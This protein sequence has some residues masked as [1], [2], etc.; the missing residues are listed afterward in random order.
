MTAISQSQTPECHTGLKSL[1]AIAGVHQVSTSVD[2]L[3]HEYVLGN[4]ELSDNQLVE[5]A[6]KLGLNAKVVSPHKAG[7]ILAGAREEGKYRASGLL[8]KFTPQ[9]FLSSVT[10]ILSRRAT[11]RPPEKLDL[12]AYIAVFPALAR[13]NN[14]S[15]VV[16]AGIQDRGGETLIGV[17]DPQAA[18]Q[19]VIL[20]PR[21]A[22]EEQWAGALILV[23]RR[24]RLDDT[25]QPFS[26]KWF[27]PEVLRQKDLLRDIILGALAIQVVGLASPLFFRV[28]LDRVLVHQ[29]GATLA[30]LTVGVVLALAFE[31]IFTYL[32][33]LLL[34]QA[35]NK[36]D[37]RLA[38]RTF[39]HLMSLPISYFEVVPGGVT[40]RHLQQ[41]EKIRGFLTGRLLTVALEATTLLVYL[42]LL[43]YF[44]VKLTL[45]V[46]GFGALVAGVILMLV[47]PFRGRLRALY[48]AEAERQA[49]LVETV[50][51]MR[52]VKSLALEPAQ[53][54]NWEE[55]S[56]KAVDLH[57]R[58][59]VIGA[60]G[61]AVTGFL[62]KVMSVAVIS[63]GAIDVFSGELSV[64]A[65]IAF[66][67]LS[68]RVI[69]P[70][71]QGASLIQDYQDTALSVRMLGEVM[72]RQSEPRSTEGGLQ[73]KVAGQIELERVT[74]RYTPG[75]A[76]ALDQIGLRIGAGKLVGVVGRS[77][78]GK[79]TVA[80]LLQGLYPLQ[81]GLIRIDGVD[82]REYDLSYLRRNV[83][84][85]PQDT[86]IFRGSVRANIALTK[87]SASFEEIVAA[88]HMAGAD[89]F[90]EQLPQGYDTELE[91]GGQ[92]LSGG[93]RQRL[94]ISRALLLQPP[95]LILDEATSALDPDSE[96]IFLDNLAGIAKGRTILIISHR[97]NTLT[98]CDAI[99]VLDRG[100]IV[101]G[102]THGELLSRC[103]IYQHLWQRQNRHL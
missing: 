70:L 37:I 86:F 9:E 17:I 69:S 19:D 46:L 36:I 23:Q 61:S 48:N 85:V 35:T 10:R 38:I 52:S 43:S 94:A 98:M 66:Q 40:V 102:G 59:G 29:S 24:Y 84:V 90:I 77:G 26:L 67:M 8:G 7:N 82:I 100:K 2:S 18:R 81:E 15:M 3:R 55:R 103:A 63:I 4:S 47:G 28:V 97:L 1:V 68:G 21:A 72:N 76:P 65:L 74:F 20:V 51:G 78:S 11:A 27:I 41:A 57:N 32:R 34:L 45:V 14:G 58:V 96:A 16:V 5:I 12:K 62:E 91:E 99:V 33:Q 101:D 71:V 30:V 89:E 79:S 50:N 54:Q 22:F 49:M 53:R 75:G 88:S 95:I 31:S 60:A 6:K 80:K 25:E 93:Q 39:A 83:C 64:G 42:P 73:P 13:L 87:R 92:N 44:S 56:A